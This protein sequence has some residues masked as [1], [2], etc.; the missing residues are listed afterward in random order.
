MQW[1]SLTQS[2]LR[3]SETACKTEGGVYWIYFFLILFFHNSDSLTVSLLLLLQCQQHTLIRGKCYFLVI[4]NL[5]LN[6]G[7]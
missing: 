2:S 3:G 5:A 6:T 1:T 4:Y 7:I